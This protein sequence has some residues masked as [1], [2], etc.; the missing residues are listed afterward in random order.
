LRSDKDVDWGQPHLPVCPSMSIDGQSLT[1]IRDTLT[2]MPPDVT[3]ERAIMSVVDKWLDDSRS[4]EPIREL[5]DI[6]NRIRALPRGDSRLASMNTLVRTFG[7]PQVLATVLDM[8][9]DSATRDGTYEEEL[10]RPSRDGTRHAV[11]GWAGQ[12]T[13][14]VSE[15][16]ESPGTVEAEPR[17]LELLGETETP[18]LWSL[19]MHIWQPNP[20][21]EGFPTGASIESGLILEPPHSHPF[22][23]ASAISVG[24]MHESIYGH[25]PSRNHAAG[26][27]SHA[28]NGRYDGVLLEHVD[29]TWPEHLYR[30]SSEL[31]T[32]ESSV[33]LKAGDSYFLP[34]D[35]IHDVE[36]E[37][38]VA[39]TTPAITVFLASEPVVVAHVYMAKTMAD[40]HEANLDVKH[41]GRAL[42]ETQWQDKLKAV[43][44]YLRGEQPTLC[45]D[46]IVRHYEEYAFFHKA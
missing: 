33:A 16:G 13:I 15:T 1:S 41:R 40:Y 12:T 34:T 28:R 32:L 5:R 23:F 17:I 30:S 4:I 25:G 35:K 45:L 38:E 9:R 21:A 3:V 11:Y 36:F 7:Q 46:D 24:V 22:D 31:T 29:D 19:A 2:S 42:S 43:A 26:D 20:H 10:T 18:G 39:R 37:A 8:L 44:A 14:F 27:D 6:L